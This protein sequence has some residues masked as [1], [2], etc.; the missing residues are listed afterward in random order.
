MLRK[1]LSQWRSQEFFAVKLISVRSS[2]IF[3]I[4]KVIKRLLQY[5]RVDLETGPI[6]LSRPTLPSLAQLLRWHRSRGWLAFYHGEHI[7]S[8]RCFVRE[9]KSKLNNCKTNIY[10]TRRQDQTSFRLCVSICSSW[11]SLN[12][13]HSEVETERVSFPKQTTIAF[14]LSEV[15]YVLMPRCRL[16]NGNLADNNKKNYVCV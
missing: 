6:D 13:N 16:V 12:I 4:W 15:C 8:L 5:S 2:L 11:E 3:S 14:A 1:T 7:V 9:K 10:S